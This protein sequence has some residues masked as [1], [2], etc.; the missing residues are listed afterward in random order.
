MDI[1]IPS[2][3]AEVTPRS[4]ARDGAQRQRRR[5]A[6]RAV[7][8]QPAHAALGVGEAAL[9]Y[10]QIAAFPRRR[11]PGFVV[12]RDLLKTLDR[13]LRPRFRHSQLRVSSST[14]RPASVGR[15]TPG[16]ARPRAGASWPP[17]SRLL[18]E[19]TIMKKP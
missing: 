7:L 13:H 5:H 1:N 14:A 17:M 10:D 19:V 4:I 15:A 18:G 6:R 3:V 12:E 9:W 8:E 16:C 11:D 2:V